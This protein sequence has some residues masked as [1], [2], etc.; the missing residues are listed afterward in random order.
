MK[1]QREIGLDFEIDKLT[2]SICCVVFISFR[3]T[4]KVL[5]KTG[6]KEFE[7]FNFDQT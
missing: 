1:K 7:E 4:E 5:A 3:I 2:N 6:K